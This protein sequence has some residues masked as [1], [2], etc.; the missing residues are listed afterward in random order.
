[1]C[2][3]PN[4]L[5]LGYSG[6]VKLPL[7]VYVYYGASYFGK[8]KINGSAALQYNFDNHGFYHLNLQTAKWNIF[9]RKS[10]ISDFVAYNYQN[11]KL[12]TGKTKNKF[13]THQIK[14]GLNLRK[15][16]GVGMGL[17]YLIADTKKIGWHF[18]GYKWFSKPDI[19]TLLTS[20]IFGSQINYNAEVIKSFHINGKLPVHRVSFGLAYENFMA[21]EDLYFK[22]QILF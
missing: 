2:Y 6:A 20:S 4:S 19:G 12:N 22:V 1:M 8:I 14:Y 5:E 17:D 10:N 13:E 16:I 7:G 21:Y 11:R 15:N 9:Y 3:V 18:Y